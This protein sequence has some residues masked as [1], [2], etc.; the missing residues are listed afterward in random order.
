M[1]DTEYLTKLENRIK[2][3]VGGAYGHQNWTT[4]H[5]PLKMFIRDDQ[6]TRREFSM[7]GEGHRLDRA[8]HSLMAVSQLT[9]HGCE[10]V[11]KPKG[12]YIATPKGIVI[13]LDREEGLYYLPLDEDQESDE[14]M[15]QTD[16]PH[17]AL[18]LSHAKQIEARAEKGMRARSDAGW[19]V[20]NTI[21]RPR[22]EVML[23]ESI[24]ERRKALDRATRGRKVGN[25]R[26]PPETQVHAAKPS[27]TVNERASLAHKGK[28][29]W[30]IIE[31]L[32]RE[33]A[34]SAT[35][36]G[37]ARRLVREGST[38]G[39]RL[40]S[41]RPNPTS[42]EDLNYMDAQ[43]KLSPGGDDATKLIEE[44]KGLRS[45]LKEAIR[46]RVT[47]DI[48]AARKRQT[49]EYQLSKVWHAVHQSIGHRGRA[50]TDRAV[51]N[52]NDK[53]PGIREMAPTWFWTLKP[54]D[55]LPPDHL[56][57]CDAC[58]RG[59]FEKRGKNRRTHLIYTPHAQRHRRKPLP[60]EDWSVD[61]AGP[62]PESFRGNRYMMLFVDTRSNMY[63][64]V[65]V[66]SKDLSVEALES[67]NCFIENHR[68]EAA[69]GHTMSRIKYLKSDRGGEFT[70]EIS[71]HA[72]DSEFNAKCKELN[73]IQDYTSAESSYMNGRA[74][75]GIRI[76]CDSWRSSLVS[77]SGDIRDW[78][79]AAEHAAYC[80]N[81]S[82]CKA[83]SDRDIR[84]WKA[85]MAECKRRGLPPPA[86]PDRTWTTRYTKFTG[87]E[88]QL[89]LCL[90]FGIHGWA[91]SG[92][93]S[94]SELERGRRT[95]FLGVSTD[96]DGYKLAGED[97]R[98]TKTIHFY[99]D[100]G[101]KPRTES[102]GLSDEDIIAQNE[103]WL[104]GEASNERYA[105]DIWGSARIPDEDKRRE[106]FE[107][108]RTEVENLDRVSGKSIQPAHDRFQ[109]IYKDR[110]EAHR[111][112][113]IAALRPDEF[114][115]E[116]EQDNPKSSR[117][118]KKSH[119]R[120]EL[121]KHCTTFAEVYDA[122]A[123]GR[124]LGSKRWGKII[125]SSDLVW[126][127][128]H[129]FVRLLPARQSADDEQPED[130]Q[131]SNTEGLTY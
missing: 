15:I 27:R 107:N 129:G 37:A 111:A 91:T 110:D 34:L 44:L 2:F 124:M 35:M 96:S 69:E 74:E 73:I 89:K 43:G 130:E 123:D 126:D 70:S 18:R 100:W 7:I 90:P 85:E 108:H 77:V 125:K 25:C 14:E 75:G 38:H 98:V 65:P 64:V 32:K 81:R 66:K 4:G 12:S 63:H 22:R 104:R 99:P 106:A 53:D 52:L 23:V 61:T 82:P 20:D 45:K 131:T 16:V 94:K 93:V 10:V 78:D 54:Q 48:H 84:L 39:K 33:S 71:G 87:L 88:A 24:Q 26:V 47:E 97:T 3:P 58:M 128:W 57:H 28:I 79:L 83:A 5:G 17:R 101:I 114:R 31:S 68:K 103:T 42:T 19:R 120:Y 95:R 76:V 72:S 13:P 121:Y 40:D 113:E 59:K 11:F 30:T 119:D 62:F 117:D 109:R 29:A 67:L 6:G 56:K 21:N 116:Y 8:V 102:Y 118:D 80:I 49:H 60:G 51:M 36:S 41:T 50:I 46:V 1:K 55:R 86:E 92:K 122:M 9:D 115:L 127:L 105:P 112:L